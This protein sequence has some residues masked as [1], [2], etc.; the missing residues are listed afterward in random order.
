MGKVEKFIEGLSPAEKHLARHLMIL[1]LH[2]AVATHVLILVLSAVRQ[3]WAMGFMG[4]AGACLYGTLLARAT[5]WM[6]DR[7]ESQ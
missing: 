1:A 3:N 6:K 4:A 2:M 5:R 7:K